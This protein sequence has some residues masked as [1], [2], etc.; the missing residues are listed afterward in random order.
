[1][2]LYGKNFGWQNELH[3]L[4]GKKEHTPQWFIFPDE[5]NHDHF[6]KNGA[7]IP[8]PKVFLDEEL[9]T[10]IDPILKSDDTNGL[11]NISTIYQPDIYL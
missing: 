4:P 3:F 5:S 8:E 10:M 1:M 11:Q 9:T 2:P 6:H 7:E